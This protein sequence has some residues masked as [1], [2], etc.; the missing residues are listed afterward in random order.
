MTDCFPRTR[1]YILVFYRWGAIKY[2]SQNSSQLDF[3]KIVHFKPVLQWL[4]IAT[5]NK[6]NYC[7]ACK[8]YR[9]CVIWPPH[10]L[11]LP[12]WTPALPEFVFL[13]HA[14]ICFYPQS[15]HYWSLYQE[16]RVLSSSLGWSCFC[17]SGCRWNSSMRIYLMNGLN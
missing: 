12:G 13:K 15:W 10:P 3:F 7:A 17:L 14:A 9:P 1:K 8:T 6:N 2:H 11:S 4:P 5:R 16:A